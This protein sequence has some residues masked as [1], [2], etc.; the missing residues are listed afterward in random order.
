MSVKLYVVTST[1]ILSPVSAVTSGSSIVKPLGGFPPPP[2]P[3]PEPI[4][5]EPS[6]LLSGNIMPLASEISIG[7]GEPPTVS[8]VV[9]S[10]PTT[11]K[12]NWNK[13][14]PSATVVPATRSSLNH[15]KV[16]SPGLGFPIPD[17]WR[18]ARFIF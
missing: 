15:E 18:L 16:I 2:P 8:G 9:T 1:Q 6:I 13:L 14:V 7:V 3:P 10:E 4:I 17:A 5:T 11:S 12:H